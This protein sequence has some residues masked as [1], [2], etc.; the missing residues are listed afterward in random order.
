VVIAGF[1]PLDVMQAILM[2][3]RQ[4]NEGRAEVENEF[5]RAVTRDGNAQGA[6]PRGRG[7]RTAPRIRV[8]GPV[9]VPYSALRIR[10]RYRLIRRRARASSLTTVGARQQGLR[11]RR[12]PARGEE[13]AGLQDLRHRLH[14]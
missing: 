14:P 8:A 3:V 4:V 1:E 7:V 6:G 12:H 2:L 11:V 10:Q 5:T 9:E 13:A